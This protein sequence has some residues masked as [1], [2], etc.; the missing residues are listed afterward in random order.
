MTLSLYL[1]KYDINPINLT[2]LSLSPDFLIEEENKGVYLLEIFFCKDNND[3]YKNKTSLNWSISNFDEDLNELE[4]LCDIK[5][6]INNNLKKIQFN[7]EKLPL[8]KARSLNQSGSWIFTTDEALLSFIK[9]MKKL[10]TYRKNN[11][12][13]NNLT[14]LIEMGIDKYIEFSDMLVFSKLISLNVKENNYNFYNFKI[15]IILINQITTFSFYI[16]ENL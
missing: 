12:H 7:L 14:L 2:K 9:H 5:D 10:N 4:L 3:F 11:Q 13:I 1:N 6:N 16:N 15:R 8:T